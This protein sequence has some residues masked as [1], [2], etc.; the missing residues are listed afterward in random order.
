LYNNIVKQVHIVQKID[1]QVLYLWLNVKTAQEG[2]D[3]RPQIEYSAI[4]YFRE[5][6]ED[7]IAL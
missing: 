6:A 3:V 4:E 7:T 2:A 1:E 5:E